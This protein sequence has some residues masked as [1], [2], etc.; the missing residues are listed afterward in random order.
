MLNAEECGISRAAAREIPICLYRNG[1]LLSIEFDTVAKHFYQDVNFGATLRSGT[2]E[3]GIS[4]AAAREILIC[5]YRNGP[6]LLNS[7]QWQ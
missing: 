2:E 7:I 6:L 5:L 3:C 1:P 4:G